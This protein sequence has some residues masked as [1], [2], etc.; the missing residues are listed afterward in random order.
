MR[1][2]AD[3][4]LVMMDPDNGLAG[5]ERMYQADGP[6]FLYLRDLE[7]VW[8][9]GKSIVTYQH[10]DRRDEAVNQ[11]FARAQT[12]RDTLEGADPIPLLFHRGTARIFMVV[13]H[14]DH[15]EV[16]DRAA[17]FAGSLWADNEHFEWVP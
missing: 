13:A 11:A 5:D 6:K 17:R 12:I 9:A 14:P 16:R 2:I 3:A 4:D 8:E 7:A 15:P 1:A 10:I